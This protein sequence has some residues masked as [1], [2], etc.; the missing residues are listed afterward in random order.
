MDY[1]DFSQN[2]A[3]DQGDYYGNAK[4]FD[5]SVLGVMDFCNLS[6]LKLRGYLFLIKLI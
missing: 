1:V 5:T 2:T 6:V 4:F 3:Q